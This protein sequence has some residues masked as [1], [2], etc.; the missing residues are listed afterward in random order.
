MAWLQKRPDVSNPTMFYTVGLNRT[1]LIVGLGNMGK[2][3]DRTR[4]NIGFMCIDEFV[5]K[6]SEM[7]PWILKKDLKCHLSSGRIGE[8]RVIAIKPTTFMNASGEAVQ[9]VS[10][11]YKIGPEHIAV[12]HDELDIT[13][14][15]VRLRVGGSSAGHNGIKS[16]SEHMSEAYGRIRIGIGHKKPPGIDSADYVLQKFSKNEQ[17]QLPNLLKEVTAI[18]SEY[19]FS[20]AVLPTET[21]NF[22]V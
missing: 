12:I 21:R 10:S 2:E 20:S 14:G 9:A 7:E 4:H 13:F 6:N 8:T 3:Y 5:A 1:L 15:Q 18:V 11:F 16:I 22:I 19:V 17:V